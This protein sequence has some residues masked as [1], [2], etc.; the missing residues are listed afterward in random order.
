MK[1]PQQH[2]GQ[3]ATRHT[4]E[5]IGFTALAIDGQGVGSKRVKQFQRPRNLYNDVQNEALIGG[6]A[7]EAYTYGRTVKEVPHTY[8]LSVCGVEKMSIEAVKSDSILLPVL[9]FEMERSINPHESTCC[10][11]SENFRGQHLCRT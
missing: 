5:H 3:G 9:C 10:L 6:G 11:G 1:D 2:P 4:N 7:P 8:L